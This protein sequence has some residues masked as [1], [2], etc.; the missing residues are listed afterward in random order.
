MN[1]NSLPFNNM[2][3]ENYKKTT[4]RS[5]IAA[6]KNLA[7]KNRTF[8]F[9]PFCHFIFEKEVERIPALWWINFHTSYYSRATEITHQIWLLIDNKKLSE[10]KA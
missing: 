1:K 10:N 5:Q 3:T 6:H 4:N 8:A 2:R 9:R 7:L